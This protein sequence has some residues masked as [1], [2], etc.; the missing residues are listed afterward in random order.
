MKNHLDE[1]GLE[2]SINITLLL[3]NSV[4]EYACCNS[5]SKQQ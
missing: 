3:Y 4:I 2:L 5:N 1:S